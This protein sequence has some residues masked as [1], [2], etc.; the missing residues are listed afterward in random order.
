MTED[1]NRQGLAG[2]DYAGSIPR[3]VVG[4][5]FRWVGGLVGS[6][7]A[8]KKRF[9]EAVWMENK[10]T[11]ETLEGNERINECGGVLL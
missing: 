6:K 9:K 4:L 3:C 7:V 10:L 11:K 2:G 5:V 1:S 8:G